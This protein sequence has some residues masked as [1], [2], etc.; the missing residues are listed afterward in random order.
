MRSWHGGS[1]DST[2]DGCAPPAGAADH[3]GEVLRVRPLVL[4][5]AVLVGGCGW[6]GPPRDVR[7]VTPDPTGTDSQPGPGAGAAHS[8]DDTTAPAANG[9]PPADDRTPTGLEDRPGTFGTLDVPTMVA[10]V[11][12]SL[13]VAATDE[14]TD[15]LSRVGVR[16]VIVDARESRRMTSGST[17]L[18]SG[19]TAIEGM[20]GEH[21]P[22]LWIVALGTN[23]V[24]AEVGADRFRAD[25]RETL[26]A[27]PT[28]APVVWVDV[29]IRDRHDDV[30]E[31]NAVLH[32]VLDARSAPTVVVDWYSSGSI[33]GVI[34]S[35]GI[36]L[37]AAG[38]A[39]FASE[40]TDAVVT[41][42]V[43]G[44]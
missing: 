39:R 20:L 37:T 32:A 26:A 19:V 21:R 6:D 14:L 7:V 10:V 12:D 16:S 13:T 15:A 17:S 23:D 3:N 43:S 18:P 35:D 24:G 36:H 1:N 40:I 29:W 34:T 33:D 8:G 41:L 38:E 25:V 2:R 4:A 42:S 22:D 31:L 27:I 5:A 9:T 30:V 11:G 44:G 28:G